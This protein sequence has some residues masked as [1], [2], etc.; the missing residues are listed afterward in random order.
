MVIHKNIF[1]F[2]FAPIKDYACIGLTGLIKNYPRL[3]S[4]MNYA[5]L[6]L[7]PGIVVTSSLFRIKFLFLNDDTLI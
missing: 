2:D 5:T 1:E 7:Y 3:K 6:H 4:V